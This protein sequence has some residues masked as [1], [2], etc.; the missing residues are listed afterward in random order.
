MSG[1]TLPSLVVILLVM[2]LAPLLADLLAGWVRVPSVVLE[3]AGG[4]LV[5]PA[6]HWVTVDDII[7]FLSQLGLAM[8]IFLA[9]LEI[10]LPRIRGRALDRALAGWG[11]SLVLGIVLGVSLARLHGTRSGLIVGLAITT[12]SLGTL[13]PI[14][15][16]SGVLGRPFGTHVL[17]GASVGEIGPIVA[18]SVLLGT[19]RP[20]RTVLVLAAFVALVFLSAWL[21]MRG[22]IGRVQRVIDTTLET[23]GQLA[24]RMVVLFLCFMLWVAQEM[25]LDVLL[26]AFAAGMV[27]RVFSAGSSEREAEL[28][29]VKLQGLGFGFL[30]PVFFVVSGVQF[31]LQSVVDDL[32]ILLV[33]PLYLLAF[34]VIRGVPTALLQREMV[35][36]EKAALTFYLATE[37]PLVVV[38]T[39]IG[40]Q[41]GR[42]SSSTAAGLVT[43]AMLSVLLYPLVAQRLIGPAE[44]E[45]GVSSAGAT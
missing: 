40:V 43:A 20:A 42:L 8:L 11:A 37:L 13:L 12:T 15:R 25:G 27:F 31:D 1:T 26:G 17:A 45:P 5:G 35:V 29:E 16:D 7:D 44:P 38:V 6:L 34:L 33:T 14:L 32:G 4:I 22:H 9:G 23:S 2:V 10:D 3:I 24:V 28:V 39:S 30:V 18:V 19:D 21:A 36:G 41:T